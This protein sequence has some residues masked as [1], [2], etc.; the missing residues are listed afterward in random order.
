VSDDPKERLEHAEHVCAHCLERLAK[1]VVIVHRKPR[2]CVV[3]AQHHGH[4]DERFVADSETEDSNRVFY[5]L[6][7]EGVKYETRAERL[8]RELAAEAEAVRKRLR[9]ES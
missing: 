4:Q 2:G 1:P 6:F 5:F 8:K 3:R 9:G 7:G